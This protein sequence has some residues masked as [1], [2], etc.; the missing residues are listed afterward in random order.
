MKSV[1]FGV[2]PL[3]VIDTGRRG[4]GAG[5]GFGARG[6][7]P[8]SAGGGDRSPGCDQDRVASGPGYFVTVLHSL[9]VVVPLGVGTARD[10]AAP[11]GVLGYAKMA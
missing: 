3:D 7:S 2:S 6:V 5:R 9:T 4:G 1:L 8:G 10:Q 11:V